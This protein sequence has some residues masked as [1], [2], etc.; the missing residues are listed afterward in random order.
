MTTDNIV[1]T[2]TGMAHGGKDTSVNFVK[3]EFE[4]NGKR[5]FC[6]AFGDYVKTLCARNFGYNEEYKE[7]YRDLLQQFGTDIVR[8]I[9]EDF[10]VRI[11]FTTI[12]M[13][14]GLYDVFLIS[15]ARFVNELQ[16]SPW[17]IGYPIF[18]VLIKKDMPPD[19]VGDQNNHVSESLANNPSDDLFHVIINNNETLEELEKMCKSTVEFI[20]TIQKNHEAISKLDSGEDIDNIFSKMIDGMEFDNEIK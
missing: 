11:V 1:M 19:L 5:V 9:E 17:R 20:L 2:F 3:E 16:P 18:N 4:K 13:L 15:D 12:D 10:W 14:R 7:D 6:L 8:N